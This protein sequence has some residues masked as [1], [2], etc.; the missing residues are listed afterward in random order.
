M[1]TNS[2]F[3]LPTWLFFLLIAALPIIVTDDVVNV[4][5][6]HGTAYVV[7]AALAVVAEAALLV[8]RRRS[9]L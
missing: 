2:G 5:R 8:E 3:H 6:G 4:L 1:T 7:T 9:R